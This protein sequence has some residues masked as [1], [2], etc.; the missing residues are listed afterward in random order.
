MHRI[1]LYKVLR[2]AQSRGLLSFDKNSDEV[3]ILNPQEFYKE[4][5]M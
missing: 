4:A 5:H 2:Q 3:F 1:T